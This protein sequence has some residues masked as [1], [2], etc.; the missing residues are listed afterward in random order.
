MFIWTEE[1]LL[2]LKTL[3][4]NG[5]GLTATEIG[6]KIGVSRNAIIGKC[7]RLKLKLPNHQ[8]MGNEQ[9]RKFTRKRILA[10]AKK[11]GKKANPRVKQKQ[12][13]NPVEKTE[14]S[15]Q[16]LTMGD[17]VKPISQRSGSDKAVYSLGS[18][19]CRWP[20]GHPKSK[21][22]HFCSAKTELGKVYCTEHMAMSSITFLGKRKT[23]HC[24]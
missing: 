1:K 19:H 2:L 10:K 21:E 11:H 8:G 13:V 6:I 4:N 5:D 7:N 24:L 23:L 15:R 12:K 9:V 20:H 22:F 18:N 16:P 14:E 17:D 3:I